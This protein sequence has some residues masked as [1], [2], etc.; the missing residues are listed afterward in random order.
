[1]K[2]YC[3]DETVTLY[4]ADCLDVL[5]SL[6]DC[7]V[8]AVICDPPYGLAN[9]DPAHVVEALTRWSQ[10]DRD[11]IPS[12]RGFMGKE[13][14]AFVPPPAVW[15]ECARILKPGGHLLAFAGSRTF[16]LMALSIRFAGFEIRDS[17]AWLYGSGFPKS[18]DVSKAIDKAAGVLEHE[19]RGFTVA[20]R[21]DKNLPNP[22]VKGYVP[23][24]PATPDAERWQGW[25]T[26]LKPSFEGI[27][28]ATK[29]RAAFEPVVVARKP[30]VGTVAANVLAHGTGALNIDGCR[31]EHDAKSAAWVDKWAGH[32]GHPERPG[33]GTMGQKFGGSPS[34]RWPANVVLDE[35]QAEALDEQSGTQRDGTA[36]K[37]NRSEDGRAPYEASSYMITDRSRE[38]QTYGGQGGASRFFYVAKAP[39][40]ERPVAFRPSCNCETMKPW[41]GQSQPRDTAGSE[42]AGDRS[43]NTSTSGSSTMDATSPR[44]TTSTTETATSST[45]TSGTSNS[46]RSSSTSESTPVANSETASGGS[47]A[48]SAAN[49][50]P[51]TSSTG[52]SARKAGPSTADAGHATSGEWSETSACGRCGAPAKREA[53]PTVKPLSLMRWLVRLV[54]PPGG[55]VLEPFAGSGTTV[56][57][58]IVEGFQC[59][60]IER[61]ADYLPL[62]RQRIDRR[63]EP[64]EALRGQAADLGLFDLL[65]GEGA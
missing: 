20:G 62:I 52:T 45:T 35:S 51:S 59:I 39:K 18:L 28:C 12:G 11:F 29:P 48:P 8:D 31:I 40:G 15:D 27:V 10:G 58:C 17:I 19:G 32:G 38:D 6:P 2:P 60:A 13:W 55:T 36:V 46:S 61:E 7:S 23:P 56:E 37:R 43:W 4:H 21:T 53:H 9:T 49:S 14:D 42:S 44:G 50:S 25:G 54:T 1:M 47:P 57:A 26:A 65:G 24:A 41:T 33:W 30:L 34:G 16:D 3:A 63:R 64:V 22:V 5:R